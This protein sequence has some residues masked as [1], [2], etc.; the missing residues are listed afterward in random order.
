LSVF[1]GK[2]YY[3][4]KVLTLISTIPFNETIRRFF[5]LNGNE[6]FWN[7]EAGNPVV[8]LDGVNA[9]VAVPADVRVEDPGV[10]F[11]NLFQP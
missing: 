1:D 3:K 10:D 2:I 4:N 9:N 5:D 11:I 6:N 7:G 8:L